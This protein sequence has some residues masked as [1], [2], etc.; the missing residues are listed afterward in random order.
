MRSYAVGYMFRKLALVMLMAS[1]EILSCGMSNMSGYGVFVD[2][3]IVAVDICES[4]V[5]EPVVPENVD[6]NTKLLLMTKGILRPISDTVTNTVEVLGILSELDESLKKGDVGY[7]FIGTSYLLVYIDADGRPRFVTTVITY[8][9]YLI[10]RIPESLKRL[11]NG[12]YETFGGDR[13]HWGIRSAKLVTR[14]QRLVSELKRKR[15]TC[16]Q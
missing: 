9:D 8:K 13:V 2:G 16:E 11:P 14:I 6:V 1:V 4:L 12:D 15:C 10:F 5:V 7:P 3:R